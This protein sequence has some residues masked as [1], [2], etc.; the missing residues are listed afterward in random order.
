MTT[1][2]DLRKYDQEMLNRV[3][4]DGIAPML[5]A[6]GVYPRLSLIYMMAARVLDVIDAHTPVAG[7]VGEDTK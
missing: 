4:Y 6:E 2:P 5:E 1:M 3:A 7:R